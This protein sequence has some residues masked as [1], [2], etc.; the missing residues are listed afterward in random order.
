MKN[1]HE[2]YIIAAGDFH[3]LVQEPDDSDY[4][5]AADAGYRI[6]CEHNII[7]DLV[8]GDF[9]SMGEMPEHPNVME[10]PVEKDDTDTMFAIKLGLERGYRNFFLYG[11]LGGSRSDHTMAN[12]QSLLFIAK[13]GGR[14]WIYGENCVWTLIRNSSVRLE[15]RGDVAVFCPDG[16]AEGVCLRGLKYELE[17]AVITS[18]FTLGVSNSMKA[19]EAEI[20]VGNGALLIMYGSEIGEKD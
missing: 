11:C 20:E 15:G 10:L 1:G 9:D 19:P 8:L 7:P 16:R 2:C 17:D 5:I 18:D 6:C 4:I 3:G 14:G 13:H 12:L